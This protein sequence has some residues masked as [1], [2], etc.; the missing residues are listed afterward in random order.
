MK[1]TKWLV[2][3]LCVSGFLTNNA[4]AQSHNFNWSQPLGSGQN[5][6]GR[7]I[8]TDDNGNV[9]STGFYRATVDFDN[10]VGTANL[11]AVA[12]ADIFVKKTDVDGN[13]QWAVSMGGTQDDVPQDVHVDA[14][15]NVFVTGYFS[16]TADFD[17]GAGTANLTSNGSSDI[18]VVKLDANGNYVWAHNFGST[19][20]DTGITLDTDNAGNVFVSGFFY[21]SADFDPGAGVATHTSNGGADG[22][23]LKL[24]ASGNYD[25][26]YSYGATN[27]D[28]ARTLAVDAAGDVYLSG[29]FN[30][31]VD[32]DPGAGVQ[33]LTTVGGSDGVLVKF[34][35][36]GVFDFAVA[37]GGTG[38]EAPWDMVI[39]NADMIIITG[40][41]NGTTDLDP[42]VGVDAH[43]AAGAN[44][45]FILKLDPTG[46]FVWSTVMGSTL[47]DE[48]FGVDVDSENNVYGTGF[49]R[50]TADFDSGSGTANLTSNGNSD[51]FVIKVSEDGDYQ[52]A[53]NV[54]GAGYEHAYKIAVDSED[55]IN[56]TGY[57][58]N[59]VD[60]D[61]GIGDES[62][63]V[64]GGN[65]IF[66]FNWKNCT[67][68]K[69]DVIAACGDYTW[70]DGV[71]YT[72]SN[73][74]AV[75]TLTNQNGC[76]SIVSLHLTI[77]N[78]SDLSVTP[79][80][81]LIC[82]ASGTA[83]IS[84]GSS[85]NGVTYYLR[86]DSDNSIVDGPLV[87]DGNGL[88]FDA[89]TLTATTTFNVYAESQNDFGVT[90]NDQNMDRLEIANP[91]TE[92]SDQ[93]T[94][95]AW[96]NV[97]NAT[98]DDQLWLTQGLLGSD[99]MSTNV[100]LWEPA[101]AG[102]TFFVNDNGTWR[103][104]VSPN[105]GTLTGWH[106]ITTTAD[107]NG[108]NIYI[109][110]VLDVSNSGGISTGIQSSPNAT[111]HIGNDVRY[112]ND[113]GR[114]GAYGIS[115]VRVWNVAKSEA[116]IAA[117][118]NSCLVGNEPGLVYYNKINNNSGTTATASI[119]DNAEFSVNMTNSSWITA[120][121]LCET[122]CT[123]EMTT[124][125]TITVAQPTTSSFNAGDCVSYTVP[126]GDETYTVSGIYMDTIP[127]MAGC[128]SIMTID[129]TIGASPSNISE[130]ACFTYT[131]PSGDETYTVSGIY[132]DTIPSI[133]G[134]DSIITIDLTI[135]TVD[136]TVTN[137][138]ATLTAGV[139]GAAYQWL[140]CD[141]GYAV[142][143]GATSQS[144]SPTSTGS[145]A[146]EITENGCVDTSACETTTEV[147]SIANVGE[148]Q[149]TIYPN[150]SNGEVWVEL[151]GSE[152][153]FTLTVLSMDGKILLQQ[154]LNSTKELLDLR[155]LASGYYLIELTNDNDRFI[156]KIRLF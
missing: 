12:G 16:G 5:E 1:I 141:N 80:T 132:N 48:G 50:G 13:F 7:S 138:A 89:G 3:A 54:G 101:G 36:A 153:E 17:P 95:E 126:S 52:W 45:Q 90:F 91:Y 67:D 32:F 26:S 27:N 114:H 66:Q 60:F 137:D 133:G 59:T 134:C 88:T 49:F 86:D 131:V 33:S 46:Q 78:L 22:F 128:D 41:Y 117:A 139:A 140:D 8:C 122:A 65:D 24:D 104:V 70:I 127:N 11:T 21:G 62:A 18:Y 109:D 148:V 98:T 116:E 76:D 69:T 61:P 19:G 51:V 130:T 15:G 68:F 119:G 121:D 99:N 110:G 34:S 144:F 142:V 108:V 145:Y 103:S 23:L 83:T 149:A 129:V 74:T 146:V 14:F 55:G 123:L 100:F 72:A 113:V 150:P 115:E 120:N 63:T 97:D 156:N 39:D 96:V 118:M 124:V 79:S 43:T 147:L 25:W 143:T 112:P 42:G 47:G 93:M 125:P 111:M 38:N 82:G 94:I 92:F 40:A 81:S 10:S 136:L 154:P 87:G 106:H 105:I 37:Y 2:G 64:V 85:D 152:E 84:T 20:G 73:Y 56:V 75:D 71:T 4:M 155:D 44:D 9:Y 28:D 53:Y 107:A 31:T 151:I 102:M 77:T 29:Y 57:F 35:N 135:N 6:D 58:Q 30:G